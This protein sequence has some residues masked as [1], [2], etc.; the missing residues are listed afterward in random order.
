MK[1]YLRRIQPEGTDL[2]ESF[3][4][5]VIGLTQ[6]DALHLV[7]PVKVKAHVTRAGDEVLTA[8]TAGSRYASVCCRCL[9]EVKR[10]WTA[11]FTLIF[12]VEKGREFIEM[13]EDIRQE[14]ILNLP[15]R[16]LC[17]DSCRG[18]CVD[19]GANLNKESCKHSRSVV[20]HK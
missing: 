14:F 17:Q 10:N 16:I 13:D 6:E 15:S 1:V 18:L 4:V 8:V 20:S 3:P 7:S 9:K 19:C 2:N 5:E 12:D 11:E